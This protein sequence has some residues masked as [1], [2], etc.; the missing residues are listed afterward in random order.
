M[1]LQRAGA[2][3]ATT[4]FWLVIAVVIVEIG[5]LWMLGVWSAITAIFSI[6]SLA[7][8]LNMDFSI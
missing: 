1:V 5:E 6:G 7:K 4:I 2:I 8:F 3:A